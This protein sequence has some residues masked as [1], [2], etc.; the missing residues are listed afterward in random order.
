MSLRLPDSGAPQLPDGRRLAP[1]AER[2]AEP[3]LALLQ[4]EGLSGRLLELAS[5]TGQ[6]AAR[7]AA[8]LP[9]LDWQP[10]DVEPANLVSIQ[11]WRAQAG[12]ANLRPPVLLDAAR[13]G[14]ST[15]WQGLDAILL[16]NL[17][18]L[19]PAPTAA[20]VLAEA[21]RALSPGG[22]LL[23][24]GPFL[25]DGKP[26]SEGDAA[27]DASLRAQDAAIGY[28]DL[29]WVTGHL[30]AAGLTARVVEMPA[31]NLMLIARSG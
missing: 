12:V 20:T 8:A 2:N 29:A 17:L 30:A 5:G 13:P 3:I 27:F 15:E 1:S 26:T 25:R 18:H 23:L 24:Y 28:K 4:A 14:W 6:H 9:R 7:F 31:N 21:A 10:S 22:K 19:I 11:A 16:V